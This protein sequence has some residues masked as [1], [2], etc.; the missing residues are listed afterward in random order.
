[1]DSDAEIARLKHELDILQSRLAIY[2]RWGRIV[3]VVFMVWA[4]LT[5]ALLVL[6]LVKLTLYDPYMGGFFIALAAIVSVMFWLSRDRTAALGRSGRSFWTDVVAPPPW[7]HSFA[8]GI[9]PFFGRV[10]SASDAELIERQIAER[11]QRLAELDAS[12]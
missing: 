11:V 5:G 10:P 8:L 6:G 7:P 4:P 1:M 2:E 9:P 12:A 3:R